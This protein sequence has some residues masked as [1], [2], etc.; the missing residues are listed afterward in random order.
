MA[1]A[2]KPQYLEV[3]MLSMFQAPLQICLIFVAFVLDGSGLTRIASC[4]C[5]IENLENPCSQERVTSGLHEESEGRRAVR[6]EAGHQVA[7]GLRYP[8][9]PC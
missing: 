8:A 6:S 5:T 7:C 3:D 1:A 9:P 2:D 4:Q